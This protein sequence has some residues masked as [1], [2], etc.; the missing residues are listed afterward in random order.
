[1]PKAKPRDFSKRKSVNGQKGGPK[2]TAPVV[3]SKVI[4]MRDQSIADIPD[5]IAEALRGIALKSEKSRINC[6]K[7]LM[8]SLSGFEQ[9]QPTVVTRIIAACLPLITDLSPLVRE[10]MVKFVMLYIQLFGSKGSKLSRKYSDLLYTQLRSGITHSW[11]SIRLETL[12]LIDRIIQHGVVIL[13]E[14]EEEL[15]QCLDKFTESSLLSVTDITMKDLS[16]KC[17]KGL[18]KALEKRKNE[19]YLR[20][21]VNTLEVEYKENQ[22]SGLIFDSPSL[23]RNFVNTWIE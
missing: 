11:S 4:K 8:K 22:F 12:Q 19:E 15:A 23:Q 2:S 16:Q 5:E 1:M 9:L 17:S 20:T 3:K 7:T 21:R 18:R 13:F 6:I 14:K 10:Q